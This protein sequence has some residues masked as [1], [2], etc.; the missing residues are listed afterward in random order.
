MCHTII[1]MC[2][3]SIPSRGHALRFKKQPFL[4]LE[5][6]FVR[7]MLFLDSKDLIKYNLLQL[8]PLKGGNSIIFLEGGTI[9][10]ESAL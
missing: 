10:V 4:F 1:N 3:L 6:L 7:F 2:H 5:F 8:I 9:T